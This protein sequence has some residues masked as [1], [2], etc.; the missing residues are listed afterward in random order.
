MKTTGLRGLLKGLFLVSTASILFLVFGEARLCADSLGTL[1][2]SYT[3]GDVQVRT[4][5]TQ[6]WVAAAVNMPLAEGDNLWVPE[7]GTA[8]VQFLNGTCARMSANSSLSVVRLTGNTYHFSLDQGNVY[9]NSQGRRKDLFQMDTPTASVRV[10]GRTVFEVDVSQ[11]G[12]GDVSAL[13]GSLAVESPSGAVTLPQGQA[14]SMAADGSAQL[15]PISQPDDWTRWNQDRDRVF[16]EHRASARYLPGDLKSYASDFDHYG[17]WVDAPGYG[18]VWSPS[19][20]IGAEWSPYREGRWCWT[21]GDYVWIAYEPWG[22][23]PYH[24]GRWSFVASLGW[25]WVPPAPA[26][27]FWAPAYVGWVYTPDYVAWV[28]LAPGETYYGYGRHGRNSVNITNVN[29]NNITIT[30]VYKNVNVTNG[31]VSVT[32]QG[33]LTGRAE[34]PRLT[35]NPFL[36]HRASVG[37]PPIQPQRE[38]FMPSTR[39]IPPR[40]RPPEHV[41][42]M[43]PRGLERPLPAGRGPGQS[44]MTP[45]R[46]PPRMPVS[47]MPEAKGPAPRPTA[48]AGTPVPERPPTARRPMPTQPAPSAPS[49][50]HVAPSKPVAQPRPQ[51]SPPP[52]SRPEGPHVAPTRPGPAQAAPRPQVAPRPAAPP[53]RPP[54][55][56]PAPAP[57]P[58]APPPQAARPQ[59]ALPLPTHH[60]RRLLPRKVRLPEVLTG[61]TERWP[62][63]FARVHPRTRSRGLTGG[64][65]RE[66]QK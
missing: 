15:R 27:V 6:D 7:G 63:Y 33:F 47:R 4:R 11:D 36:G 48:R 28:P 21:G 65:G 56:R 59:P 52:R 19:L 3:Q 49:P 32:R 29:I 18:M 35:G 40:M 34:H 46:T 57:R 45:G 38:T 9:V 53:P 12:Y 55:V 42:T 1:R 62:G 14:L 43:I 41:T 31:V 2:L 51:A 66:G 50:R 23:C 5:D 39:Q 37:R 30:N 26:A 54:E 25:C 60:R 16:Y 58:A 20:T 8:E 24:Y 61:G 10:F 44:V 13:Q 22:W 17:R 64:L